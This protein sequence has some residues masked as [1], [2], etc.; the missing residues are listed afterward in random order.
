MSRHDDQVRLKDMLDHAREA[1]EMSRG[2]SVEHLTQDRIFSLAI[3][4]LLEIIGEAAARTSEQ[5]KSEL[6][7]I[8]WLAI[9]GL[10]NR[11]IHGYGDIDF[12][13]VWEVISRDLP[14]LIVQ[15]SA[16]VGNRT[17]QPR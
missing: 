9:T 5:T 3:V 13:I 4:R 14:G 1:V 8:P 6:P 12:G 2:R 7:R 10:R 17:R 11:L 16:A 15:L